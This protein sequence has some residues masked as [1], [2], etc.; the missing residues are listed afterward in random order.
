MRRHK[1]IRIQLYLPESFE[2]IILSAGILDDHEVCNIL[3]HPYDYID[4]KEYYSWERYFTSLLVDKS[5]GTWLQYSKSKLNPV[6]LQGKC[7]Q[8]ILSVLPDAFLSI[9]NKERREIG[10]CAGVSSTIKD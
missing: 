7:R 6:F 10:T 9:L 8:Q 4:G 5:R 1:K 2:W 3:E